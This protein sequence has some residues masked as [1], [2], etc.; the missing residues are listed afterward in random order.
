[1]ACRTA[2]LGE[3][4]ERCP[5][6][7]LA[8]YA[9]SSCRKRP[10][11][12]CQ[13]WTTAQW[14]AARHAAWLS[15]PSCHTVLTVPHALIVGNQRPLCAYCCVLSARHSASVV[16]SICT[17]SSAPRWSCTPG[18]RRSMPPAL[19]TVW[20]PRVCEP[21][22]G[23]AGCSPRHASSAL[24]RPC[25]PSSVPSA[26]PPYHRPPAQRRG[27]PPRR[28][29]SAGRPQAAPPSSTHSRARRGWCRPSSRARGQPRS[30]TLWAALRTAARWPLIASRM[31]LTA[32][33]AA[34][35]ASGA[36]ASRGRP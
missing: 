29:P 30:S 24:S 35:I 3:H 19:A 2:Q 33:A 12:T 15:T 6:G 11:P 31:S 36:R 22:T 25:A 18:T 17:A 34:R 5:Q 23:R 4:A 16:S 7:G 21:R 9:A 10:C 1:M 27:A 20:C 28:E 13:P 14:G 32:A 26:W 8:R